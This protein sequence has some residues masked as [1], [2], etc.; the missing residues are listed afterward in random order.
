MMDKNHEHGLFHNR[1]VTNLVVAFLCAATVLVIFQALSTL[2][3]FGE[4]PN[5]AQNV[6][7]VS[8]EGKVS[9]APDIATISF[10]VS[11]D[12]STVAAAQDAAAKKENAALAALKPF[13]LADK[14]IQTSSYNVYPKYSSSQP[15]VYNAV[16][17][18]VIPCPP[19]ESKIIGY[20]TS[21]TVTL[22][23]RNLDD[24]GKIVT[25]LGGAGISNLNGPNFTIENPDAVQAQARDKAIVDARAK[26]GDL[27]KA[28]GVRLVRVVNYSENGGGY[29]VP[30]YGAKA[31]AMTSSGAATV[32]SIP[33]GE[34]TVTVDVSVTY[35]IR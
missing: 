27:A 33:T 19:T 32:P 24:V 26:A 34:N 10:T 4:S 14:D 18:V 35:E 30:M 5:G 3:N 21:Q 6:V 2:D 15:C 7:T 1:A 8:G 17:G 13:N 9:T 16:N 31:D 28:L 11:E 22:K 12:A 29:P 23:V 20:T 25:A